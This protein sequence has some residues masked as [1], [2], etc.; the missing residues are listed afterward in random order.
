MLAAAASAQAQAGKYTECP[1]AGD[2]ILLDVS[3]ATCE[4]ARALAVS[5]APV[6]SANVEAALIAA[7]WTPLRAS[8]TGFQDSYDLVATRGLA[9]VM[10]RRPGD[11]PDLDGWMAG[12]ELVFSR[13]PLVPGAPAPKGASVCTSA[14]LIRLGS[15]PGGLSAGHCGDVT[16]KGTTRRRNAALRRPPQ[17]GIVLGGVQR[18]LLRRA[19]KLDALVLPVPS[20]AGRP[21]AAVVDRG[22]FSPPWFVRGTARPALGRRVCFTGRTSGIDQCGKIVRSFPG[23]GRLPCTTIT[24]RSGDSGGPVYT[25]PAPDGTVRAVGVTTLVFGLLQSMCFT[26]IAPVLDALNAELVTFPGV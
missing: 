6:P 17:P 16:K 4:E 15:H 2:A 9:A 11:A 22:L 19:R 25:A 24:A 13:A 14:F 23:T 21:A 26:P 3:V 8:A 5:L 20:G 10:L 12:R 18:N 1:K 7:G